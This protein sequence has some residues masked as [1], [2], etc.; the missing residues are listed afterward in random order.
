MSSAQPEDVP[1]ERRCDAS[2]HRHRPLRLGVTLDGV[3]LRPNPELTALRYDHTDR[4]MSP[5]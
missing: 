1:R 3:L 5:R 2:R 4:T